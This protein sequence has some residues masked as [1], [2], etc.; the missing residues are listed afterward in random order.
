MNPEEASEG[1]AEAPYE[2]A[3]SSADT[4]SI[5]EALAADVAE[6]TKTDLADE[7]EET[8]NRLLRT[9]A[10]LDNFRKRAR[11]ELE[12]A[13]RY[14][15]ISLM[16]D[17]LP[18][19]DNLNRAIEAAEKSDSASGLL[20]GVKM[21]VEQFGSVLKQYHCVPIEAAGERFDPNVHEAIAQLPSP[22]HA[23]GS[24]MSVTQTGFLLHDRVVRPSQVI[25][26]APSSDPPSGDNETETT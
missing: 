8:R 9:Q 4:L 21:V 2:D 3:A 26:A 13:Q 11:R 10:E 1:N 25:V 7:L 14:A 24:V 22:D 6:Q 19:L 18:V 15:S 16:R 12:D 5:D 23:A 20:D 17:L